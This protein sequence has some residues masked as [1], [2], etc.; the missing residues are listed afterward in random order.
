MALFGRG[1]AYNNGRVRACVRVC[2]KLF[3]FRSNPTDNSQAGG[4]EGEAAVG[5]GVVGQNTHTVAGR[6]SCAPWVYRWTHAIIT[7]FCLVSTVA[8]SP[9]TRHKT[10]NQA[11][12]AR[13]QRL[14]LGSGE[15]LQNPMSHSQPHIP[16][17][18]RLP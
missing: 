6:A 5:G 15:Q 4:G 10:D 18:S 12:L 13:H 2:G 3:F 9:F 16:P 14:H 1:S 17:A 11:G 7:V 8:D